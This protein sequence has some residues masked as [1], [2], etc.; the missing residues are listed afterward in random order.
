MKASVIFSL[1]AQYVFSS[2]MD[3]HLV[4][5]TSAGFVRGIFS[6]VDHSIRTWLGIP[7]A[8]PPL[9]SLRW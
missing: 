2:Y 4:V 6:T 5:N 3:E 1:F 9:G 7:Y 8:Q